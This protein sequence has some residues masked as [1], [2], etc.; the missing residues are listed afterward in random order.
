MGAVSQLTDQVSKALGTD[1][2]NGGL[3]HEPLLLAAGAGTAAYLSGG[4]SLGATGAVTAGEG[5]SLAAGDSAFNAA[6]ASSAVADAST[7]AAATGSGF[8]WGIGSAPLSLDIGSAASAIGTAAIG[9]GKAVLPSLILANASQNT[10]QRTQYAAQMPNYGAVHDSQLSV[11]P[12]STTYPS[13]S[14]A[15]VQSN[16]IVL[17]GIVAVGFF[18]FTKK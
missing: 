3:L 18:A 17:V 6:L 16:L 2:S 11:Q 12:N 9:V 7:V 1:G 5:L 4:L 15:Q 13:S 14:A 8:S 10:A